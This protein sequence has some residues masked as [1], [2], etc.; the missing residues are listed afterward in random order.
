MPADAPCSRREEF[1]GPRE[2]E[3]RIRRCAASRTARLG[4]LA[5]DDRR[6]RVARRCAR[7]LGID[8]ERQIAGPALLD[9][10]HAVD[11]DLAVALEAAPEALCQFCE[12]QMTAVYRTRRPHE[13]AHAPRHGVAVRWKKLARCSSR[14]VDATACT[15]S[16]R[17]SGAS[18]IIV[19]SDESGALAS[20]STA[21]SRDP[22]GRR[23]RT[24]NARRCGTRSST[25]RKIRA[26]K[27]D[28][29]AGGDAARG[30]R[31]PARS[32]A[33]PSR[34]RS[35]RASSSHRLRLG[36][37]RRDRPD[38]RPRRAA[39]RAAAVRRSIPRPSA[40]SAP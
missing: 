23:G 4:A 7:V 13:P 19:R 37:D 20:R 25:P 1:H 34:A 3:V 18:A 29:R 11:L 9:A 2:G 10:G 12:R 14:S 40:A 22:G 39:A 30:C 32:D 21:R 31:P 24:G 6:R 26:G 35:D 16:A 27:E 36:Q 8:E 28:Q 15:R 5:D 38:R 17:A 33:A